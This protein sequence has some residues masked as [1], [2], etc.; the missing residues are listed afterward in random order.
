MVTTHSVL[1]LSKRP[2]EKLKIE[3][4]NDTRKVKYTLVNS[5]KR[6]IGIIIPKECKCTGSLSRTKYDM[7]HNLIASQYISI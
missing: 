3:K 2:R 4:D 6:G 7:I 1:N 5:W